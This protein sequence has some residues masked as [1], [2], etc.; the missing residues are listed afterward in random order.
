MSDNKE[1]AYD[2]LLELDDEEKADAEATHLPWGMPTGPVDA[3]NEQILHLHEY[4]INYDNDLRVP[5]WVAYQLREHDLRTS[6]E[7]STSAC[8]H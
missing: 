8:R 4:I 6:R 7:R 5:I 1:A 2:M 3:T